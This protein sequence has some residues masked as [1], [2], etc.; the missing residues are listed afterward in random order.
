ML[1]PLNEFTEPTRLKSK[2]KNVPLSEYIQMIGESFP[3][4]L[5]EACRHYG[6]Q[7]SKMQLARAQHL[8]SGHRT[9]LLMSFRGSSK[10]FDIDAYIVWRLLRVPDT[11]ILLLSA[12]EEN[13]ARHVRRITNMI[14]ALPCSNT[15]Q[16][17]KMTMTGF[18][19]AHARVEDVLSFQTAGIYSAIEGR[20][21]DLIILDDC[22]V[23]RNSET[24]ALREKLLNRFSEVQ[25]I[26]HP[27]SP[28]RHNNGVLPVPEQTTAVYIGTPQNEDSCY[29]AKEDANE[30]GETKS[31]P[32]KDAQSFVVPALAPNGRST[33]PERF[34]TVQLVNKKLTMTSPEW[35]LQMMLDPSALDKT[36]RVLAT[37]K[38]I[39][40]NIPLSQPYLFIDPAGEGREGDEAAICVAGRG[41][42]NDRA[43]INVKH[44]SGYRC[45]SDEFCQHVVR[46]CRDYNVRKVL[47]EGNL[48]AW[49][50]LIRKAINSAGCSAF[51]ESF[52]ST[53]KKHDRLVQT[54]EPTVNTGSVVFDPSVLR[55]KET[56]NQFKN[57]TF[58]SKSL[59][60]DDRLDALSFA[61]ATFLPTIRTDTKSGE[62]SVIRF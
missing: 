48:S 16:Y 33:F 23:K 20:R 56:A 51:V 17:S 4:F 5:T 34:S 61:V 52:T 3:A 54:L 49:P 12:K 26:L 57:F 24:E 29:F 37:E 62:N 47:V 59:K 6:H 55:D 14:A 21:A 15:W 32:L 38:L 31:H 35:E 36:M 25:S 18:Q 44:I 60:H 10:S 2:S 39:Q 41:T 28:Y 50:T 13:A 7:I 53:G 42:R 30:D 11:K 8:Q 45:N 27:T 19:L 40:E 46:L 9:N 1:L 22:E 58:N 43:V